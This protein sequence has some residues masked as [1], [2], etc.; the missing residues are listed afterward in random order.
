MKKF[1]LFFLCIAAVSCAKNEAKSIST[2]QSN[3]VTVPAPSVK[4]VFFTYEL[5]SKSDKSIMMKTTEI[6]E[7]SHK[8]GE[9][10]KVEKDFIK[11][12]ENSSDAQTH[13]LWEFK[14][15]SFNTYDEAKN[16]RDY[17]EEHAIGNKIK[18]LQEKKNIIYPEIDS[19]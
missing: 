3:T 15:R 9:L 14:V 17:E 8:D 10:Y 19:I 2:N 5:L 7:S 11:K 4:Y 18:E 6:F 16:A 13:D 12:F 1:V